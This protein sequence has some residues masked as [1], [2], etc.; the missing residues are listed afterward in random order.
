MY[1][2]QV[3][4]SGNTSMTKRFNSKNAAMSYARQLKA[5]G[6][7]GYVFNMKSAEVVAKF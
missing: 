1:N 2:W 3:C 6:F 5:D 7:T 4:V